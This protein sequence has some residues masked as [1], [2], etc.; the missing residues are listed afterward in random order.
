M[1]KRLRTPC[2]ASQAPKM[3]GAGSGWRPFLPFLGPERSRSRC[4][5]SA[6]GMC[7]SR[8]C[9]SPESGCARSWRQ[10]KMRHSPRCAASSAVETKVLKAKPAMQPLVEVHFG[11]FHRRFVRTRV[12]EPLL[13]E[14]APPAIE[15]LA[16]FLVFERRLDIG[17]LLRLD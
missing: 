3:S 6:P 4:A 16:D 8:Y 13:P 9:R 14:R 1:L 7:A 5:K 17:G 11:V 2:V 15:A 12:I 10:S